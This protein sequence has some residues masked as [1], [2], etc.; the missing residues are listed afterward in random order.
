MLAAQFGFLPKR[1][2]FERARA[3]ALKKSKQSHTIN[4]LTP[5]GYPLGAESPTSVLVPPLTTAGILW[6][7]LSTAG[8]AASAYHGYK[9]NNSVGWGIAWAFLGGLV[10]IV[11]VPIAIAQGF[12][13]RKGG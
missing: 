7:L 8:V 13:K 10:P 12:G 9:R 6:S 11:T 4:G 5:I 2:M 1:S 3:Y